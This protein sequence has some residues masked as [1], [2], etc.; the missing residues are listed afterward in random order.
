MGPQRVLLS[1]ARGGRASSSSLVPLNRS[2]TSSG[3]ISDQNV[4]IGH[5]AA[6]LVRFD[7]SM[8]ACGT[9]WHCKHPNRAPGTA[10]RRVKWAMEAPLIL[11]M[12]EVRLRVCRR[13]LSRGG[14]LDRLNRR[15]DSYSTP[16]IDPIGAYRFQPIAMAALPPNHVPVWGDQQDAHRSKLKGGRQVEPETSMSM[17]HVQTRSSRGRSIMVLLLGRSKPASGSLN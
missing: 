2:S 6:P 12:K 9:Q 17:G 1:L 14:P 3:G 4:P 16:P 7:R 10:T 11:K 8:A 5:E 13:R 15:L